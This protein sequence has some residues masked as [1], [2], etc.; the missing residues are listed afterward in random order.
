M[1]R[2]VRVVNGHVNGMGRHEMHTK[3]DKE[4]SPQATIWNADK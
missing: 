3:F 4:T 2:N 1:P